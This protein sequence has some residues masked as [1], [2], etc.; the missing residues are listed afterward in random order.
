MKKD[1]GVKIEE[2]WEKDDG[3]RMDGLIRVE[4][5]IKSQG[6]NSAQIWWAWYEIK[7]IL[8]KSNPYRPPML[9]RL[10]FHKNRFQEPSNIASGIWCPRCGKEIDPPIVWP[11]PER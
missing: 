4:R 3:T 10:G 2:F 7:K 5:F 11:T 6:T 8:K 1:Q 9:C